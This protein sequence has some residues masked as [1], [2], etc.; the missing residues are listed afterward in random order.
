VKLKV[1]GVFTKIA[2]I[3]N[4]TL[5]QGDAGFESEFTLPF[6][7]IMLDADQLNRTMGDELTWRCWYNHS[8]P[9]LPKPCDWWAHSKGEFPI[10]DEYQGDWILI[11]V[12][13][14]RV[15]EFEAEQDAKG[16]SIPAFRL[17]KLVL[18]PRHGGLTEVKG[19]L[20]VRPGIGKENLLLQ[21]H[22]HSTVMLSF[23][24]TK[25]VP[26]DAKQVE[27]P[28]EQPSEPKSEP[29]SLGEAIAQYH[30]QR[31]EI[32]S[33]QDG[34]QES[35]EAD[36]SVSTQA[37]EGSEAVTP[38]TETQVQPKPEEASV[39]SVGPLN[40]LFDNDPLGLG[41]PDEDFTKREPSK[42]YDETLANDIASEQWH[43]QQQAA[44]DRAYASATDLND[45]EQRLRKELES[46]GGKDA[47]V[48]DGKVR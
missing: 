26:K 43:K 23:S 22:Q 5:M 46:M 13:G 35:I 31:A 21:E 48:I 11:R 2:K 10:P 42:H 38:D 3:S 18:T 9:A 47:R 44:R 7:G 36:N 41:L 6:S 17:S 45:F 37:V 25:P 16:K 39:A 14:D 15:I 1:D 40:E 8:P 19:N 29:R 12:S 33:K 28:L 30:R 4:N 27:L 34:A 24:D 20:H 32:E